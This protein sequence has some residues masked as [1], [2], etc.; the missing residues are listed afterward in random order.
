M[1]SCIVGNG[2]AYDCPR[3]RLLGMSKVVRDMLDGTAA[4]EISLP[5]IPSVERL[6][7]LVEYAHPACLQD[8]VNK[9]NDADYLYCE[10]VLTSCIARLVLVVEN[11]GEE[12]VEIVLSGLVPTVAKTVLS[13]VH[14]IEFTIS[15]LKDIV[16]FPLPWHLDY[17]MQHIGKFA[18][19]RR[20]TKL[21]ISAVNSLSLVKMYEL[22]PCMEDEGPAKT[23]EVVDAVKRGEVDKAVSLSS[24]RCDIVNIAAAYYGQAEILLHPQVAHDRW[25]L[26]ERNVFCILGMRGYA[27]VLSLVLNKTRSVR[28][29]AAYSWNYGHAEAFLKFLPNREELVKW[30]PYQ[31]SVGDAL[32]SDTGVVNHVTAVLNAIGCGDFG[33][34]SFALEQC[35]DDEYTEIMYH[36]RKGDYANWSGSDLFLRQLRD[37]LPRK[38]RRAIVNKC[39]KHD[40]SRIHRDGW[41]PTIF[42]NV[43]HDAAVSRAHPVFDRIYNI[44][45]E[46]T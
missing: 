24:D 30:L 45:T 34:Y 17:A 7:N 14:A 10:S 41:L 33:A 8:L 3:Q 40:P 46:V 26:S 31:R 37:S 44:F 25:W 29:A 15:A 28:D 43:H 38:V 22:F 4:N 18:R 20:T 32:I 35:S 16:S 21:G 42:G 1:I 39:M 11:N 36:I 19:K 13:Q 27:N 6:R 12:A 9:A 2:E 5:L 23:R